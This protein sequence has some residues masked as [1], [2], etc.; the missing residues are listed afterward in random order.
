VDIVHINLDDSDQMDGAAYQTLDY[1]RSGEDY[2]ALHRGLQ[3]RSTEDLQIDG[4]RKSDRYK[5]AVKGSRD[6]ATKG[7][8]NQDV[9]VIKNRS[10]VEEK[11]QKVDMVGMAND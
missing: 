10:A 8:M 1:D 4:A 9:H 2:Y 7:G 11:D 5:R 6:T 3:S